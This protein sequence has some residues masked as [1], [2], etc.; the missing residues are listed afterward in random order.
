[1]V[2]HTQR[3]LGGLRKFGDFIPEQFSKTVGRGVCYQS[4][5]LREYPALLEEK[6]AKRKREKHVVNFFLILF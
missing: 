2:D 4:F 3:I 5:Y 6:A 1:M